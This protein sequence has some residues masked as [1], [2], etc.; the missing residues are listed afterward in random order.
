MI[1]NL[2]NLCKLDPQNFSPIQYAN[3]IEYVSIKEPLL[4]PLPYPSFSPAPPCLPPPLP[5]TPT[6]LPPSLLRIIVL[7]T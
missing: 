5:L 2:Q 1:H 7:W 6:S 3:C 4:P